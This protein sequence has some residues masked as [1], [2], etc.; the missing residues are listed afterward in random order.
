M[1]FSVIHTN[2]NGAEERVTFSNFAEAQK[3]YD[4]Y[5]GKYKLAQAFRQKV[6]L[7]NDCTGAVM[8]EA[9]FLPKVSHA[10]PMH[11]YDAV[12]GFTVKSKNGVP[13]FTTNSYAVARRAATLTKGAYVSYQ[14]KH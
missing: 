12:K 14:M 2:R 5:G 4:S 9:D 6:Q 11:G 8:F 7:V 13:L 1:K 10:K 3:H